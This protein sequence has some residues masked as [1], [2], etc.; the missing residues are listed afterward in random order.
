MSDPLS[1]AGGDATARVDG[2]VA[3]AKAKA[4]RYQAMQAAVGQV[5]VTESSRDGLVTVTVDSAGNITALRITDQVRELSGAQVATAVLDIV[6]RAQS[7]LPERLGEVMAAT[8]GDDKQT[9][10]TIVGNYRAKFPEP[11]PE[12]PPQPAPDHVR[13]IGAEEE[14][15]APPPARPKPKPRPRPGDGEPDDDFGQSFM[16]RE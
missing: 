1:A 5:S 8:I 16:V 14:P 6:R 7:R 11:E 4:Q 3:Q 12:E 2:W 15:P 9:M 13:R 10:D